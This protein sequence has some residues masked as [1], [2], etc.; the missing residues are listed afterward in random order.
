MIKIKLN[1][2]CMQCSL[3][4][5]DCWSVHRS[6][7]FLMWMASTHDTIIIL[8]VPAGCTGLFQPIDVGF[9]QIFKHSLKISAH[10][11]VVQEVLSQLKEG[12]AISDVKVD[13]TLKVLCD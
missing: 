10:S 1:L 12:V 11:D 3:W 7:E 8:F 6:K 2:P 9:Q 4:L 13:T 5:I